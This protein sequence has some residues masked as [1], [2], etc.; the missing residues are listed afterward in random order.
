VIRDVVGVRF[1][2][3]ADYAFANDQVTFR[4]LLRTDGKRVDLTA[5]K[6]YRNGAS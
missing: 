2:A 1:E 4:A 5:V 3:S 6:F